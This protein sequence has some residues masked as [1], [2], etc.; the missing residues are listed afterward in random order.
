MAKKNKERQIG[1]KTGD[2]A[3]P[4]K[5]GLIDPRYKSFIYTV[6][7]TVIAIVFFIKNNTGADPAPGPYPPGVQGKGVLVDSSDVNP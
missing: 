2:A 1:K 4:E 3:T 7:F 5:K 6:I